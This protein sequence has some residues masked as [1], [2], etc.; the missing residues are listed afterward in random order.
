[1]NI[2]ETERLILRPFQEKDAEAMYKNWTYDKRVAKYCRWTPHQSISETYDYLSMCLAKEYCWAITVKDKD[3]PVGCV[4]VVKANDKGTPE[5]GY[6]LS[7]DYWNQGIMSE[8][9]S[10]VISELFSCGIDEICAW[11]AVDN[12][13]SG[14]VMEKAGMTYIRNGWAQKKFGSNEQIEV[15]YYEIRKNRR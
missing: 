1:M 10:A 11:H 12:P 9:V 14:K 5:I 2:I 15:K 8:A 4:D 6:V 13:A 3:E 7:F